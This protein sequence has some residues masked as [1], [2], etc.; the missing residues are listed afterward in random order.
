MCP[1]ACTVAGLVLQQTHFAGFR[2]ADNE[3]KC[4]ESFLRVASLQ[5]QLDDSTQKHATE[6]EKD[7]KRNAAEV[8]VFP[9]FAGFP[10][11][12]ID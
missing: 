8:C 2:A 7:R 5:K 6:L 11:I 9:T 4:E 1:R 10:M 12:A 3:R